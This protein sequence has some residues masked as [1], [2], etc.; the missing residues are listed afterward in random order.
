MAQLLINR[1]SKPQQYIYSIV[2]IVSVSAICLALEEFI[3][4][5][6]VAFILLLAVSA[7]AVLFDILPVLVSAALSAFIWDFFFITPRPGSKPR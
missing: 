4:Y 6:V 7:L 3:G 1:L 2:L 5:R